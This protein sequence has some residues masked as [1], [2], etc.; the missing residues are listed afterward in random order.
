MTS[1]SG[2]PTQG[3]PSGFSGYSG[4]PPFVDLSGQHTAVSKINQTVTVTAE[5]I[6]QLNAFDEAIDTQL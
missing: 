4:A 6:V 3:T 5:S 2:Q 1:P